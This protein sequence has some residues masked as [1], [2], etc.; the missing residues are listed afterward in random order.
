[1]KFGWQFLRTKVD[2]ARFSN[3]DKPGLCHVDD[4][5]IFGPVNGGIFLLLQ[6]G[7]LTP[8]AQEI[9]LRNNYNGLYVQD[10]WKLLKNLTVNLGLRWEHDSEFTSRQTFRRVWESPGQVTPKTVIRAHFGKFFDQFRLGLV[11]QVPAFGGSRPE[12]GTVAVLSPRVLRVAQFCLAVLPVLSV[13]PG[14]AFRI[15]LTDAQIAATGAVCITGG[16]TDCRRGQAQSTWSLR[17]TR[18]F[19]PM[20]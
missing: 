5:L 20:R 4:Y 7:G 18:P 6:A 14:P 11:S 8:E 10:D 12:N 1:M 16:R 3:F 19:R 13:F 9:H 17:G 15:V 2:G